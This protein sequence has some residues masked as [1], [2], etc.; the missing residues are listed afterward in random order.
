MTL[1]SEYRLP[2]LNTRILNSAQLKAVVE[3]KNALHA[4]L[5]NMTGV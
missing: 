5:V 2:F 3:G 1:G 4:L